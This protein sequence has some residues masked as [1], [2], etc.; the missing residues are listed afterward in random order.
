MNQARLRRLAEE[1]GEAGFDVDVTSERGAIVIAEVDYALRPNVHERRVPSVGAI[2]E[3]TTAPDAWEVGT[4][5]LVTRRPIE[6]MPLTGSRLFADGLSSWLIRRTSGNDEWA[7]FDRPAGSERDLVVLAE[8]MGATIVQRHPNGTVRLVGDHGV[9]RWDGLSW[10]HEPPIG[11][12]IDSIAA[13]PEHGDRS[14]L[15]LLLEFAVHDL[16]A[17]GIGAILVYRPDATSASTIELRL[18]SPPPL[19]VRR[20]SDLAPLRHALGQIDG[21]AVIDAD[22]VLRELGVRLV[23]SPEAE[24]VVAGIGGMRHTSGRR[25][26]FDDP[27]A[28]VIVISEDGPVTVLRNGELLGRST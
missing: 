21:A 7:V 15:E 26:S 12:W 13:C 8:S 1:L 14:V 24:T 10:R 27:A 23:P 3:P 22:G 17:R 4:Q 20:P 16:G 28:T 19:D 18:P 25:Y 6:A 2:I 11:A 5:L 9:L